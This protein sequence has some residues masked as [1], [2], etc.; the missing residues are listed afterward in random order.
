MFKQILIPTDGSKVAQK[1]VK[2]GLA[3]AKALDA[4]VVGYHATEPIE[5]VSYVEGAAITP[6]TLKAFQE[7]REAE[8]RRYLEDF[9]KAAAAAG[10]PAET[11]ITASA[12]PYQGIIA[13]ARKKKCDAIFMASHGRGEIATLLLGSVTQKVLAHSTIPVVVYR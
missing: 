9:S 1:A 3:L 2:A 13:A 5:R 11:L 4:R 12:T 10:V 7:Q 6:R 8:G